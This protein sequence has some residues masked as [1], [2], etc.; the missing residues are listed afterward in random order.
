MMIQCAC[1]VLMVTQQSSPCLSHLS[2]EVNN[3]TCLS[4]VQ[5]KWSQ[6]HKP[7]H[8]LLFSIY[9]LTL[10]PITMTSLLECTDAQPTKYIF[11]Q[12]TYLSHETLFYL[13]SCDLSKLGKKSPK[14]YFQSQFSTPEN[15]LIILKKNYVKILD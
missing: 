7:L 4:S 13:T 5:C 6:G 8:C 10:L 11:F 3:G 12:K 2:C 1:V 14:F 9:G 15:S